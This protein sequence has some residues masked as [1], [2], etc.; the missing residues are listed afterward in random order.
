MQVDAQLE[1]A[2]KM[3]S[4]YWAP[5]EGHCGDCRISDSDGRQ[6]RSPNSCDGPTTSF[7]ADGDTDFVRLRYGTENR[8]AGTNQNDARG[9]AQIRRASFTDRAALFSNLGQA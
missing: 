2:N 3:I 4:A 9:A 7:C 8:V 5:C 6:V 1:V